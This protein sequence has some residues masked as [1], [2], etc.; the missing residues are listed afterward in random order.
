MCNLM[1]SSSIFSKRLIY[2]VIL[3]YYDSFASKNLICPFILLIHQIL[4]GGN[5]WKVTVLEKSNNSVML[6]N[7]LPT[8]IFLPPLVGTCLIAKLRHE[9]SNSGYRSNIA[10][11][12]CASLLF[13]I[14]REQG[15]LDTE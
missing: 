2:N 4:V 9:K 12:H 13:C 5:K 15:D 6:K 3:N 11:A 14:I 1:W 7:S 8:K 10:S